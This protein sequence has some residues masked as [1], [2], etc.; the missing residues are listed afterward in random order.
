MAAFM[1]QYWS[2]NAVSMTVSFN[3]ESEGD[4]IVPCLNFFQYKLKGVSMLPRRK[5]A[6][7]QMPI[8]AI[9]EDQY[10]EMI[11]KIK[12]LNF[13]K[14]SGNKADVE[15]FCDGDACTI[16]MSDEVVEETKDEEKSE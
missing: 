3:P 11:T 16:Q 9:T 7:P 13:S 1:Q 10:K 15:R 6:Y 8:E 12:K 14:L 2:D 4:Q 5:N